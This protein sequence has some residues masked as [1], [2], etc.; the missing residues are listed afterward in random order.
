MELIY[1]Q[2]QEKKKKIIRYL[3][4]LQEILSIYLFERLLPEY[5]EVEDVRLHFGL[6]RVLQYDCM[7]GSREATGSKLLTPAGCCL[8]S[9]QW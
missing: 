3:L 4:T 2:Y 5:Q 1:S 9:Y 7:D 8:R 6:E